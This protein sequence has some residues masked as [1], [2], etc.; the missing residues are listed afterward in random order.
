MSVYFQL[1][2][3]VGA[4]L[5][6]IDGR[7]GR[8][9]SRAAIAALPIGATLLFVGWVLAQHELVLT[10]VGAIALGYGVAFAVRRAREE[11]H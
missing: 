3:I 2:T 4:V 1:G 5:G 7:P 11:G 6:W 8:G 10:S 9:D